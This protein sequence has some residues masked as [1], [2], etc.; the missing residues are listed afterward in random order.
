MGLFDQI[1][2][3]LNNPNQA[4]SSDQL[5]NI[6]NTAQQLSQN[7]GVSPQASQTVMSMVGSQVR[8]ALQQK[9]SEVGNDSVQDMVNQFGGTSPNSQAVQMLFSPQ[10]QQQV[11]QTISQHTGINSE[12]IAAILPMAVP[13]ILNLL[14]TGT[15]TQSPE[16]SA[17]N[18]VLNGFLDADGD[19]DVD[20]ADAM[21]LAGQYLQK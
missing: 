12:T 11:I 10:Q 5:G 2:G 4:G 16:S 19:G 9:R 20:V 18:N 21:R 3:A 13:L 14:K 7:F 17:S 6:L 1:I 8:S 15:S